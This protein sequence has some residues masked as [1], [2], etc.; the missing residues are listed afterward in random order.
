M[1]RF[2]EA[3]GKIVEG[4]VSSLKDDVLSAFDVVVNCTGVKAREIVPDDRVFS[5]R[6][7]VL[8]VR[9]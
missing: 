2:Q 1:K 9:T 8:K 6:G 3:G 7:Q 4:A 5:V